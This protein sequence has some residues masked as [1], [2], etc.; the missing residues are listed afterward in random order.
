MV[1]AAR[2][3]TGGAQS[4]RRAPDLLERLADAAE[5][6]AS[7]DRVAGQGHAPDES[8]QEPGVRCVAMPLRGAPA[9][10][11]VSGPDPGRT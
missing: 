7:P 9:P 8:E 4:L 10:V 6:P 1:A 2:E 11:S 5:L 3:S